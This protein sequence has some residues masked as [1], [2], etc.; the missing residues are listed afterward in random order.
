[1]KNKKSKKL[2]GIDI[3]ICI[4]NSNE[5]DTLTIGKPYKIISMCRDSMF[6]LYIFIKND[7]GHEAWYKNKNFRPRKN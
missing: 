7:T 1:M 5:K 2:I 3:Y 4:D 6:N